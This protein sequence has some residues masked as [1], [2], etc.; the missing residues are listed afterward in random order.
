[1]QQFHRISALLQKAA[2]AAKSSNWT[3]RSETHLN[4]MK[5]QALTK[6]KKNIYRLVKIGEEYDKITK[7]LKE[8]F[9]AVLKTIF[10]GWEIPNHYN[11]Y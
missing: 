6:G 4:N 5:L 9:D 11:N 8:G 2:N 1:M 3:N 10:F 7:T